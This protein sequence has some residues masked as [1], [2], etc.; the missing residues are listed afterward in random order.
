MSE[1]AK[2]L[3][4]SRTTLWEKMQ[5]LAIGQRSDFRK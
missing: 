3:K 5:K 2:L 1:A 4:I